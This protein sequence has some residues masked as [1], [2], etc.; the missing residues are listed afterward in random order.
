MTDAFG[1]PKLERGIPESPLAEAEAAGAVKKLAIL[2]APSHPP[3][4][5]RPVTNLGR[6]FGQFAELQQQ[7]AEQVVALEDSV[8]HQKQ[9]LAAAMAQLPELRERINW[10]IASFYEQSKKDES[11]RDRLAKHETSLES[12]TETVRAMREQQ[13]RWQS[14]FDEVIAS[15]VRAKAALTRE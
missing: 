2:P 15:L 12:L 4:E 1:A 11:V 6:V 7:I 14:A 10:L 13:T 3:R 8:H 5:S 9:D